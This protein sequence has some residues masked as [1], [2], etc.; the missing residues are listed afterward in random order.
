MTRSSMSSRLLACG[1][2]AYALGA[3]VRPSVARACSPADD[4]QSASLRLP[5]DGGVLPQGSR[6]VFDGGGL[7]LESRVALIDGV[8]ASLELET[9]LGS[10][11]PSGAL[12]SVSPAP[13]PGQELAIYECPEGPCD[14]LELELEPIARLIGA[15]EDTVAPPPVSSDIQLTYR[16]DTED[17]CN[18]EPQR[19]RRWTVAATTDVPIDEPLLYEIVLSTSTEERTDFVA[20]THSPPGLFFELPGSAPLEGEVCVTVRVL[21]LAMNAS[22]SSSVCIDADPL[23]APMAED[24]PDGGCALGAGS[25]G[26]PPP[27]WALVVL[28]LASGRRRITDGRSSFRG[29]AALRHSALLA[30]RSRRGRHE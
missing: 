8:E 26:Q 23:E 29:P 15:D 1:A 3:S 27:H 7:D 24:V 5:V 19:L 11:Y 13:Q 16:D 30:R 6:L 25:P 28:L 10:N 17:D 22:P 9:R 4:P 21:D 2:L 12:V 14:P 18:D 20:A